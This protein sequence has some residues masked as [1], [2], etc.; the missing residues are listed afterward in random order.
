MLSMLAHDL[1]TGLARKLTYAGTQFAKHSFAKPKTILKA[2]AAAT[3]N[4]KRL[5][6]AFGANKTSKHWESR[7]ASWRITKL[8]GTFRFALSF[9]HLFEHH[10]LMFVGTRRGSTE[11]PT[12]QN[13]SECSS[14]LEPPCYEA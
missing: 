10:T 9:G 11:K 5:Q 14:A 6:S 7:H 13:G 2:E 8:H 3:P 1:E 4:K 12:A